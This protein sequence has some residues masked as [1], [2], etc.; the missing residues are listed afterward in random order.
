MN[1]LAH[2]YLSGESEPIATGN[3]IGDWIKGSGFKKYPPEIQKGIL[4]HRCIDSYTDHH[5]TFKKSKQR[6]TGEFKKYSGIVIDIFYDH[7]LATDWN[8][9]SPISLGEFVDKL[10][11][12]LTRHQYLLTPEMT[13][14]TTRFM[15]HRRMESYATVEGIEGVLHAMVR[16]TS[17]P[18]RTDYAIDNLKTHYDGYRKEFCNYFTHLIGYIED[19]FE[20]SINGNLP[21]QDDLN[22]LMV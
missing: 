6:L 17:L 19:R 3:F 20:I 1:F 21:R 18:D 13:E 11:D 16:R 22:S 8:C 10:N 5:P 15:N 2:T 9:F 12:I 4:L 7:F 14:F